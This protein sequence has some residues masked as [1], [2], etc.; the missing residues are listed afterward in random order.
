MSLSIWQ[1]VYKL[2]DDWDV[3]IREAASILVQ[4]CAP[5]DTVKHFNKMKRDQYSLQ[6]NQM[7]NQH[8]TGS[9]PF[10]INKNASTAEGIS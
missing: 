1:A 10:S 6:M 7:L 3:S 9:E 4:L 2:Q 8:R 5:P